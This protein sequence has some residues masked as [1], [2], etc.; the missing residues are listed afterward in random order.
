MVLDNKKL[1]IDITVVGDPVVVSPLV[2]LPAAVPF[3]LQID[4]PTPLNTPLPPPSPPHVPP[5]MPPPLPTEPIP[6]ISL[7]MSH[8]DFF[9]YKEDDLVVEFHQNKW[10]KYV[11]RTKLK[12]VPFHQWRLKKW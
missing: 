10:K 12:S 9:A 2:N 6:L 4:V 3:P 5:P 8:S 11:E 1:T 7:P